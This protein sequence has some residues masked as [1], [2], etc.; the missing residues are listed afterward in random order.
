MP[1][2]E[3]ISKNYNQ[4]TKSKLVISISTILSQFNSIKSR[5]NLILIFL[6]E[7]LNLNQQ[8]G[9]SNQAINWNWLRN[10]KVQ[11][12]S[13]EMVPYSWPELAEFRR[14]GESFIGFNGNFRRKGGRFRQREGKREEFTT[15]SGRLAVDL[16]A[17]RR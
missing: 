2:N 15:S 6:Q 3:T 17:G 12:K 5:L 14:E 4:Y 13:F 1:G 9:G 8:I 11:M 7:P 16:L 10:I